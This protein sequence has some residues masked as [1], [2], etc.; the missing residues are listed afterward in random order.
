MSEKKSKLKGL[1]LTL[2]VLL[3]AVAAVVILT[4]RS[5]AQKKQ[6]DTEKVKEQIFAVNTTLSVEGQIIDYLYVNGDIIAKESVDV[7]AD[8]TGKLVDI[9]VQLGDKVRK[10]DILAYIDPSRPG[11]NFA[12]SPVKSPIQGTVTSF[13]GTNGSTVSQQTPV[14]TIGDL[15]NLQVRTFISERKISHIALGM[16]GEITFESY[17]GETFNAVIKELSPVIDPSSRTMQIKM[18]MINPDSRIK[19]G[20]FSKIKITT[21]VKDN[22]VKVPSDCINE[23]FG[24]KFIYVI[25]SE[26]TAEKRLITEGIRINDISEILSGLSAGENVVIQGQSLLEDGVKVKVIKEVAPLSQTIK[27]EA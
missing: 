8:T 10:G 26:N 25:N 17:P 11:M 3:I 20:M 12:N 6:V 22:I 2:A 7:F 23:R 15:S 21:T 19:S 13:P 16:P 27:E 4:Q 18:N 14:A 24:E 5:N 9:R 1:I